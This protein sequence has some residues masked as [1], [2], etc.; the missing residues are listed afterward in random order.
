MNRLERIFVNVLKQCADLK[1][2]DALIVSDF[3]YDRV[4][5]NALRSA[6][7]K[8]GARPIVLTIDSDALTAESV[9]KSVIAS[10]KNTDLVL[11]CTHNLLPQQIRKDA[12]EAGARLI[13]MSGVDR[14]IVERCFD[15][16]YNDLSRRT[17][18]LAETF[19]SGK[20]ATIRTEGGTELS[21]QLAGRKSAYLDGIAR[22]KGQLSVLPAGVVAVAPLEGTAKGTIVIDGSVVEIGIVKSPIRCVVEDGR[23]VDIEGG[24]EARK[25]R[26]LLSG[27][28]SAGFC[29]AE[30]GGGT[31]P[32]A[33]YSGNILEDERIYASGHVGFGRNSHIGG[34]IESK[35]HID[36]TM[37]RPKIY[38]DGKEVVGSGK[39]HITRQSVS[40]SGH[41][42]S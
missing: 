9:P 32:K 40:H 5:V 24:K 31:N 25:F 7:G 34:T 21:V 10:M 36:S 2:E 27:D 14:E 12:A 42:A 19:Q 30:I 22:T 18:L 38:V 23:I 26:T 3:R 29:V 11:F 8:L 39:I 33:K 16:D 20:E 1:M 6:I 15:I 13:S 37:K 17:R 35:I 28:S 41:T 4:I